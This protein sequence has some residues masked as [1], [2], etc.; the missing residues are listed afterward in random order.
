MGANG[1]PATEQNGSELPAARLAML[2]MFG[3]KAEMESDKIR[4]ALPESIGQFMVLK[5]G[6]ALN[7]IVWCSA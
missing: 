6:A 1:L 2:A 4:A 7:S 5:I 3:K